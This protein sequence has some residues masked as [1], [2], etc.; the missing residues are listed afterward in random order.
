ML[1]LDIFHP[2]RWHLLSLT[3][4]LYFSSTGSMRSNSWCTAGSL[5]SRHGAHSPR[6]WHNTSSREQRSWLALFLSVASF[7]AS[8]ARRSNCHCRKKQPKVYCK[9]TAH[10]FLP[11]ASTVV[12]IANRN[13]PK[14][15][16]WIG[17]PLVFNVMLWQCLPEFFLCSLVLSLFLPS[18]L[19][20]LFSFFSSLLFYVNHEYISTRGRFDAPGIYFHSACQNSK[21]AVMR[22]YVGFLRAPSV[23]RAGTA[24]FSHVLCATFL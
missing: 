14:L 17:S 3:S 21:H 19:L 5:L 23:I 18:L 15:A 12:M 24:A 20:F 13:L 22:R 4:S 10:L 1:Y 9:Y 7:W 8:W 2:S 6:E 16:E 11:P